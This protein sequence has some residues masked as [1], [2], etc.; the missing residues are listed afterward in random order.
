MTSLS[1]E[2]PIK[3]KD[4]HKMHD[5]FLAHKGRLHQ[6]DENKSEYVSALC[7]YIHFGIMWI[8]ADFFLFFLSDHFEL[9][10]GCTSLPLY[11]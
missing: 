4:K 1:V 2:M 7:I 9:F 8:Q 11:L 5:N 3:I 6:R 10:Y